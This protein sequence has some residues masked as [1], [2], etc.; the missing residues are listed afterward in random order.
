MASR[1][2]ILIFMT[3]QEQADVV[4]PGH[5][6]PTPFAERLA[7][8]GIRFTQAYTPAAH[9][10]PS[11]AT[12]MTGLYPSR[13]GVFNNVC[14]P[15]AIHYGLAEGVTTFSELLREAGYNLTLCGKWHVS[16]EED[17]ADRGWEER[18][19]TGTKETSHQRSIDQWRQGPANTDDN[20]RRRGHVQRPGWGDFVLYKTL[21]NGGP[22]GYEEL[23]DAKVVQAA[24]DA[25]GEL[26]AQEQPWCLF[27]GPVGP[28]DPYNVPQKFVEKIKL[29][30]VPLPESYDDTLE[31]KPRIVQRQ[32]R[33]LWDQLS[34]EEVRE[35]VAHYWAYCNLEDA[36]FGEVLD[37]LDASGQAD[38]TLVI[39]LSDHG[40]YM[41][42]H[43]LYLK[44]VAAFREAY[45]IPCIMRWPK[46][47]AEPGRTVDAFITLADF[48][49]TFLELAGVPVP[50]GLTGRSLVP[51]LRG[52][53]PAD[54][55]DAVYSQFNGVELYYTQRI[56]ATKSH[57]YV[58]NGF[59]FDELYDL[60]KDP[61]EMV[62]VVDKPEYQEVKRELVCK[63]W[64]FAA[65]EQD[66]I[67]N[68]YGTVALAPWGP[69]D[70][71]AQERSA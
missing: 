48:A 25:L 40:D 59:D 53:T 37:A 17:P 68:P 11:R 12:F 15:T 24:V 61:L 1:P 22:K 32:R 56:V 55:P 46:G 27:V 43:G 18:E 41:G 29:E 4:A 7:A 20:T 34:K 45:H 8:E 54:W 38:N 10:C 2:N 62:N 26:T 19:V 9:C 35:S 42:A 21:P 52:E 13:H 3:D 60:E 69:A 50:E 66:M 65:Q 6:C 14:T 33:Q 70:G 36:L 63:M 47:L 28:H 30:D 31:D 64:H 67:F 49:P 58:Y 5:P 16:V 23:H 51:F 44:G 39:F 71:L 57:K